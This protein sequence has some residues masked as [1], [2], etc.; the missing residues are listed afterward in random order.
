[1]EHFNF[2]GGV[3]LHNN[4]PN[5]QTIHVEHVRGSEECIKIL[6]WNCKGLMTKNNQDHKTPLI[7]K[8]TKDI[9]LFLATETSSTCDNPVKARDLYTDQIL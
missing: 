5:E 9:D 2:S 4:S 6:F 1:M 3:P 7:R 8:L